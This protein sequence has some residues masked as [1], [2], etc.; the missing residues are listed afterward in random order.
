M[1]SLAFSYLY[2][3]TKCNLRWDQIVPCGAKILLVNSSVWVSSYDCA[4]PPFSSCYVVTPAVSVFTRP[5]NKH[6]YSSALTHSPSLRT[7][8]PYPQKPNTKHNS[9]LFHLTMGSCGRCCRHPN[10]SAGR[11]LNYSGAFLSACKNHQIFKKRPD[12]VICSFCEGRC[13]IFTHQPSKGQWLSLAL[14]AAHLDLEAMIQKGKTGFFL[15]QCVSHNCVIWGTVSWQGCI[16]PWC[17][18]QNTSYGCVCRCIH[19]QVIVFSFNS[20]SCS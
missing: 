18:S 2:T 4:W 9:G 20:P 17:C 3:S 10:K 16:Q 11:E 1:L 6:S 13:F 8:S 19:S 12:A 7:K 15:Q 5:H 14:L